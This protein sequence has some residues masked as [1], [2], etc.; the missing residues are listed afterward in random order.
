MSQPEKNAAQGNRQDSPKEELL[1][2]GRLLEK[3]GRLR[4]AVS[5]YTEALA[6]GEHDPQW[7][8]RLGCTY[9][10]LEQPSDADAQAGRDEPAELRLQIVQTAQL[11]GLE[12]RVFRVPPHPPRPR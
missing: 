12:A 6:T 8:Y 2:A 5:T 1:A 9:L 7:E 3:Q 10:K 11:N 4:D